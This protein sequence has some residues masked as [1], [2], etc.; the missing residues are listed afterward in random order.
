M[1]QGL[2]MDI[3]I[4]ELKLLLS[5]V[6]IKRNKLADAKETL[7]MTKAAGMYL[8]VVEGMDDFTSY[9]NFDREVYVSAGVSDLLISEYMGDKNKI[10]YGLRDAILKLERQYILSNYVEKNDYYRMLNGLP[11]YTDTDFIYV[12]TNEYEISTTIPIHQLDTTNM[13]RLMNSGLL[14]TI[15]AAN[16]TKT[17]LN[18]IGDYSITIYKSRKALNYEL[19]YCTTTDPDNIT[20][21]FKKFYTNA[22]EYYLNAIYNTNLANTYTYYDNFI[23]FC[24]IIMSIQR[25]CAS[26]FK[27]G[28]TRDFYDT[29]LIRYL[30]DS[31][32]IPYI[33]DMTM[34]QMKIMAKNLN[35]FLSMKSTTKVLFDLCSIF[36]FSNINIYKYLLVRDHVTDSV[37]GKPIFP[38]KTTANGDGTFSTGLDYATMYNVYFQKVNVETTDLATALEDKTNKVDYASMVANDIY[39]VDDDNLR[40]K[41]YTAKFNHIESKYISMDIMFKITAMMYEICHTF[42][43]I[44]DNHSEFSKV[45]ISV[46]KISSKQQDLFTLII[47]LC[48]TFCKRFGFTGEI[49]LK[50]ASIAYVYGFNFGADLTKIITDIYSSKYIDSSV[51]KYLINFTVNSSKDVD[52]IYTNIKTLKD[53][54]VEQMASTKDINVYRAYEALYKSVLVVQDKD[55][56][57]KKTDG[58]LA[59]SYID[60]LKD[61]SPE[62]YTF[63]EDLDIADDKNTVALMESVLYK[64]ED[65]S[66]SYKYL[67]TA[68]ESNALF[69]VLIRL[70]KLFK[71]YTVDLTSA[72]ILYLFDDRYFNM[73]KVLDGM[74][75][76]NTKMYVSDKIKAIYLDMISTISVT[77]PEE[78]K[79]AILDK[80]KYLVKSYAK[81][82]I[83]MRDDYFITSNMHVKSKLMSQYADDFNFSVNIP[84]D[85]KLKLYDKMT[86]TVIRSFG[87]ELIG[88]KDQVA[89]VLSNTDVTTRLMLNTS[90]LIEV[91]K[92]TDSNIS[93][94]VKFSTEVVH[95]FVTSSLI[96]KCVGFIM[97]NIYT[98]TKLNALDF[99]H[100]E[101]NAPLEDK[102]TIRDSVSVIDTD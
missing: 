22:R 86:N 4:K 42:R 102:L 43:M 29:Q 6:V 21:D 93:M 56:I 46:P 82:K 51:V 18:Y 81:E 92:E 35:I 44:I 26:I 2:Q 13:A 71:S 28:I 75:A 49:P 84:E 47:F 100:G 85:E 94:N 95:D 24:I 20:A 63:L 70:V 45:T 16:P 67:H 78:D 36:G 83:D 89:S 54:I 97:D 41:I 58:T 31:Y 61:L 9:V 39:W 52:R 38:T 25:L 68:V 99:I 60:M 57:Y 73:F 66:I 8:M 59:A 23:G 48:A 34:D 7:D 74:H 1:Y 27:Q 30:F 76:I 64:L 15:I 91:E 65:L 5:S 12:P 14:T 98:Q 77:I 101:V 72:G 37:T 62:L 69:T 90:N 19:L 40:E 79:M 32:N 33:D 88:L 11:D 96:V 53:F 87:N 3:F 10:P 80:I 55:T 17:Y 50:P